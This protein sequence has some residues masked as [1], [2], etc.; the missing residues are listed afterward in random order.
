MEHLSNSL[1]GCCIGCLDCIN[2]A[3]AHVSHHITKDAV[4]ISSSD[5]DFV[6]PVDQLLWAVICGVGE[7]TVLE[8]LLVLL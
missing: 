8:G 7:G 1:L 6:V 3:C 4:A 5:P 2:G